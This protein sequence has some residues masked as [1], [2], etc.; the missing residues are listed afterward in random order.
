MVN[1]NN[2]EYLSLIDII[3]IL[4]KRM[5]FIVF[6]TLLCT[7]IM[8]AK[9]TYFSTPMY[10]AYTTAVIVKGDSKI[11]EDYQ[12]TQ[13]DVLLYQKIAETYVE[14]AKSNLVIDKTA[15][16]LKSYSAAQLRSMVTVAQ[17]GGTQIIE[18]TVTGSNREVTSIANVYCDNFIK[19]SR[20]ILPIGTIE[21]LDIAKT[22]VDPL[23]TNA[24]N[25]IGIAFLLGLITAIGIVFFRYYLESLKIRN[26]EQVINILNIPVLVTIS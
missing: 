25:N 10:R 1:V 2:F 17:K 5:V 14:I 7:G 12:Y 13:N 8:V 20:N 21:V 26:E 18:L 4:K 9:S 15:E 22:S 24:T 11:I 16:E 3:K 19:E 23:A 6:V